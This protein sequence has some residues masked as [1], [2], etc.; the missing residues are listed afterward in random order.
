[1]RCLAKAH[2]DYEGDYTRL[3]DLARTTLVFTSVPLLLEAL[4]WFLG[5]GSQAAA[6]LGFRV[7]RAKDRLSHR[8]CVT[9]SHMPQRPRCR[10]A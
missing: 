1:M 6:Q 8:W 10:A 9:T 5:D 3:T 7:R 2:A 4:Q